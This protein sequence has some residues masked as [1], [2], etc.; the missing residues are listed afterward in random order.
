MNVRAGTLISKRRAHLQSSWGRF[1]RDASLREPPP[2][3]RSDKYD[4]AAFACALI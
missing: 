1:K 3:T 4:P 2:V